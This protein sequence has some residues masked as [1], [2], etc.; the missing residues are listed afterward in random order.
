MDG[1]YPRTSSK[2]LR[3]R[4]PEKQ[5]ERNVARERSKLSVA[6]V[7]SF[8]NLSSIVFNVLFLRSTIPF[9]LCLRAG[10][11][12]NSIECEWKNSLQGRL[13]ISSSVEAA[14]GVPCR[15]NH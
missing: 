5:F 7:F 1:A 6:V 11:G 12:L 15:F 8:V 10:R 14:R 4:E 2:E 3:R 13:F 9:L